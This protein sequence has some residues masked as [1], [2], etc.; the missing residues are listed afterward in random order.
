M[1]AEAQHPSPRASRHQS[2]T[3][4][5][6]TLYDVVEV[7]QEEVSSDEEGLVAEVVADLVNSGRIR[8]TGNPEGLGVD[9][10]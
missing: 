3:I 5:T 1:Q 6:T 10:A 9:M 8:F 4:F 2:T 7:V